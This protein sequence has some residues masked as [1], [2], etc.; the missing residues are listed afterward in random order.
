M[1]EVKLREVRSSIAACHVEEGSTLRAR[2]A[3]NTK[4]RSLYAQLDS[5][6]TTL[7]KLQAEVQASGQDA[8]EIEVTLGIR[9]KS[10]K[11]L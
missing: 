2:Q 6:R 3:A 10:S 7:D 1:M 8:A 11:W 5:C 4:R 9:Q